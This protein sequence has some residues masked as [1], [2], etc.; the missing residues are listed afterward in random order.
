MAKRSAS[1]SDATKHQRHDAEGIDHE[2]AVG[3]AARAEGAGWAEGAR[4]GPAR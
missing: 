2:I 4:G 1:V 3:G